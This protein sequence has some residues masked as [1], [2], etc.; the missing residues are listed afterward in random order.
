MDSH[1]NL[2][3]GELIQFVNPEL[4]Y[5]CSMDWNER[6]ITLRSEMP[7]S[8]KTGWSRAEL[9]RRAGV[10]YDI[11]NKYERGDINQPNDDVLAK[12]AEALGTTTVFLR[13]G[14]SSKREPVASTLSGLKIHGEVAAGMWLES[15]LF[16][17]ET[18]VDSPI[19]GDARYPISAQ[20]LLRVRGESLNKVAQDGD[21]L[22]CAD[23][24]GTGI[25]IKEG[26]IAIVERSRDE[27][28]TIERT[29]KRLI[30]KNGEIEL[31]PESNDPRFQESVIYREGDEEFTSVQ[32]RAKVIAI[33]RQFA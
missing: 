10:S 27:G 31:R 1:S 7:G 12:I 21:L 28:A 5:S 16:E 29:A 19:G 4:E 33:V 17:E 8:K 23:Y 2:C 20:Y 11:L 9:A 32:I 26:D 15:T 3:I 22:L 25:D 30:R 6:I 18:V 13:Y 24:F 14:G